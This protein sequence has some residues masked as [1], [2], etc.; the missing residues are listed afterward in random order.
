M[1]DHLIQLNNKIHLRDKQLKCFNELVEFMLGSEPK[2]DSE[3][4]I[5]YTAVKERQ[6][7]IM[8]MKD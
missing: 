1:S 7:Q 8:E 3:E 4:M 2:K 5:Q 6:K